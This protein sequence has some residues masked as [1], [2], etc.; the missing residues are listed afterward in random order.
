MAVFDL[1]KWADYKMA[2]KGYQ[3]SNA[4]YQDLLQDVL[5]ASGQAFFNYLRDLT[6]SEV[7]EANITRDTVLLELAQAQ[8]EA[9][10]A[11]RLDVTRA[12]VR[13]A[14]DIREKLEQETRVLRSE[15][16]LKRLLNYDYVKPLA[17]SRRQGAVAPEDLNVP[18][19][20]ILSK[21]DDYHAAQLE[22]ERAKLER[23]A[24]GWDQL[25][26]ASVFGDYGYAS[27]DVMS[28]R[29]DNVWQIGVE[30]S[31]PVFEGFRIRSNKLRT[32]AIVR[33]KAYYIQDLTKRIE[34][35]YLVGS[36][37]LK[38]R[39]KQIAIT[40]KKL[41]LSQEELELAR[42]R[43]ANGV[44][45]NRDVVDAQNGLA[46]AQ[47]EYIDAIYQYNLGRLSL[48]RILGNVWL[49]VESSNKE[50]I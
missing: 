37:N 44:A 12:E 50:N 21:R 34:Q 7:I 17:L 39:Y 47:D 6:R 30:L 24:A 29:K 5:A 43:F 31:M 4:S 45:D 19:D 26:S 20:W 49:I 18:L 33:E 46:L 15:T 32:N 41:E 25:P 48:A 1:R 8:F 3:I 40:Q 10:V 2:K 27:S 16:E 23:K 13:L 11:M 42:D 38:S 14:E 28:S 35:E 9:G 36:Q 22:T